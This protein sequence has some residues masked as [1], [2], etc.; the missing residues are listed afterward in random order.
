MAKATFAHYADELQAQIAA[1]EHKPGLRAIYRRWYER[2]VAQLSPQEPTVEIG[3]GCGNFKRFYPRALATDVVRAGDWIDQIVDARNMP[4]ADNSIG[5]FVLIDCLHHLPRPYAFLRQACRQLQPGGR[6]V[7]L[8]PAATP[9]A[10]LVWWLCHHEPVRMNQ[11]FVSEDSLP[12]PENDGFTYANMA[13]AQVLFV[14]R[15][16][17]LAQHAAG[18]RL[19]QVEFSDFVAYPASG[20]FSYRSLVSGPWLDHW[21]RWEALLL[22][23]WLARWIGLRLLIV[24]EKR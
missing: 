17:A 14:K 20:G 7:L 18:L 22:P 13:T 21:H 8:E 4:F 23:G 2:I 11:D 5:N 6:L 15:H 9:A 16:A 24:L 3:A 1:W 19:V 10:R 12:E